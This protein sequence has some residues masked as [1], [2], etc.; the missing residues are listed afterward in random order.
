MSVQYI[1]SIVFFCFFSFFFLRWL[2]YIYTYIITLHYSTLDYTTLHYITLHH[3]TLHYF[4]LHYITL[5]TLHYITLHYIT[6]HYITL[7]YITLHYIHTYIH[8]YIHIYIYVVEQV[9]M[10]TT[11]ATQMVVAC[12][13]QVSI[14]RFKGTAWE[15]VRHLAI[16]A[17]TIRAIK[18]E[19]PGK[20]W[21]SLRRPDKWILRKKGEPEHH[22]LS[23]TWSCLSTISQLEF[24]LILNW[25]GHSNGMRHGLCATLARKY[26]GY[27]VH[28]YHQLFMVDDHPL[29]SGHPRKRGTQNPTRCKGKTW[30]LIVTF[31]P[32]FLKVLTCYKIVYNEKV[33]Y[34]HP[35]SQTF[36]A[37][38][39]PRGPRPVVGA[40]TKG[41]HEGSL[42][43][44]WR[45]HDCRHPL[46]TELSCDASTRAIP[47]KVNWWSWHVGHVPQ[48]YIEGFCFFKVYCYNF[49]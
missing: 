34:C 41:V 31:H 43:G 20:T 8:T 30:Q 10:W 5:I 7:H 19:K 36:P 21:E 46:G 25:V 45:A 49:G 44:P 27:T 32:W 28:I 47:N 22:C 6:L 3:I 26:E 12:R 15:R 38:G 11:Q 33:T 16:F 48:V 29:Y 18:N 42:A 23:V 14:W 39:A 40:A 9:L 2:I 17:L 1:C 24:L 37:P 13:G 35:G 4:T